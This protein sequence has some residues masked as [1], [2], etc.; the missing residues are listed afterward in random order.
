[1]ELI[2]VCNC[3]FFWGENTFLGAGPKYATIQLSDLG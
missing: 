1:M 2:I 3:G